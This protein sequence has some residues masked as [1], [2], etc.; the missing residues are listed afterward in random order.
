MRVAFRALA[1]LSF[2]VLAGPFEARAQ[3][4]PSPYTF[5]DQRQEVGL[6]SGYV[7]AGTGRFGYGPSGGT[8]FGA[9]YAIQLSGPLALEG[10]LGL[11]RGT[12]DVVSP[13]RPEN[14][15]SVGKANVNLVSM[16][17]RL[18]L[19][20]TGDRA[21]HE[22]QPYIVLGG[23]IIWDALGQ[24]TVD[25]LIDP[26]QVFHFGLTFVGITGAGVR[27]FLTQRFG[28]R[29]DGTF[30]LWKLTTPSG[31]GDPQFGFAAVGKS[32]WASS[33]SIT[34]SLFYRW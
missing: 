11:V 10:V 17:G 13:A 5:I 18:R 14:D 3:T 28:L 12:R 31:W 22:L 32:E 26:N 4:I 15:R 21:W 8:A 30:S 2:V 29:G 24:Q 9:R 7:N 34:G 20:A 1:V 27:W 23:G 6:F 19:S 33:L 25:Q 16:D